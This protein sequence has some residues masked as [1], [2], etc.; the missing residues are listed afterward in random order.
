MDEV[1][2][3]FRR[4]SGFF[5]RRGGWKQALAEWR[6]RRHARR[7]LGQSSFAN[8]SYAVAASALRLMPS[9]I[10]ATVYKLAN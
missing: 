4:S 3:N 2:L 7:S 10:Q 8:F 9:K 5:A 6:V 1:V